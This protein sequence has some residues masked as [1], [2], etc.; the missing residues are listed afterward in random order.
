MLVQDGP[1]GKLVMLK[2]ELLLRPYF[3]GKGIVWRS[4]LVQIAG[5]LFEVATPTSSRPGRQMSE[6]KIWATGR[7]LL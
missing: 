7:Y 6:S 2:G 5:N 3:G 1:A 4:V